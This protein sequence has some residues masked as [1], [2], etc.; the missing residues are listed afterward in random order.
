MHIWQLQR[1]LVVND[2]ADT[3][4]LLEV[5]WDV[6]ALRDQFTISLF[7][8]VGYLLNGSVLTGFRLWLLGVTK[9][10]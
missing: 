8:F 6:G 2:L 3:D 7:N 10:I 5:F 1:K 9:R 4:V